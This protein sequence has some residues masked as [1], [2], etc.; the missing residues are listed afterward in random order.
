MHA[1]LTPVSDSGAN[2][3]HTGLRVLRPMLLR[4]LQTIHGY[5]EY[6]SNPPSN[7]H[8]YAKPGQFGVR[9]C[10][11]LSTHDANYTCRNLASRILR[12]T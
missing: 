8:N 5:A 3:N 2:R 7:G 11:Q 9:L 6:S 10:T 12:V 1:G 4:L